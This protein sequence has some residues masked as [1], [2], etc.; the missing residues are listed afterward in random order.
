MTTTA[1]QSHPTVTG[2]GVALAGSMAAGLAAGSHPTTLLFPGIDASWPRAL[3]TALVG[4]P[5][6]AGWVDTV[7]TDLDDWAQTPQVRALGL[8][9]DGFSP[10]LPTSPEA[11]IGP[12]AATGPFSLVGNLLTNLV[13]LAALDDEGLRAASTAASTRSAGHSAGLLAAVVATAR[14][15]DGLV[16]VAVAADAA[17][18][19]AIMGAQAA[20]HPWAV[21]DSAVA[22][23][24]A[25]EESAGTPMVAISGPRTARLAA[26]LAGIGAGERIAIGVVTGPTRHILAGDPT[27]LAHLRTGL[28]GLSQGEATKRAAGQLGGTPFRF[29]WEPLASSVP[30]HHPD[31]DGAA[32]DALARIAELGL[33]LPSIGAARITDPAT[34]QD[35]AAEGTLEAVV[36][37]VLAR[38]HDWASAVTRSVSAG[39]VAIMVSPM[40]ALAG[41]TAADLRGRAAL[42]IDPST[43]AGRMALFTPGSAP[44]IP[45][46]YERFAP[47]AVRANDGTL[48]LANLHTRLSGRSPMILP[49][50]TPSTV[51]APIVVAAANGGHVAELAGGGQVTERIFTE[52]M[53]EV[54]EGLEP[55]QEVVLNALFLDPYLWNLQVGRERLVQRA[56]AAGAPINGVTISAG[57]PDKLEALA[58]LDELAAAGIWL[59]A[60]KPGTVAQVQEVLSI[61]AD[62]PHTLWIHLEG[63]TAGGHHSWE[64]LDELLLSTYHL[65]REHENVVLAVGGGIA[66]PERAGALLTGTWAHAH[67]AATMPVDAILLG[68]VTMATRE[69]AASPS[70]KAALVAAA[71]HDSWVARGSVAGGTTSGRSGLNADIHF[72]D[73]SAAGAARLLDS[74]AGDASAVQARRE[75]IIEALAATAKPYFGDVA[76]MTYAEMLARFVELA[77]LGRDGRY[78]DG[79]WL[80]ATHR[81]RFLALL[82]QAEARLNPADT[83]RIE[84]LFADPASVD[85]PSAALDQLVD[86][87]PAARTAL[88]HPADVAHYVSVARMPGKPVPFVPVID[89]DVRRWYQS[90]SLWQSHSDLFDADQVLIIPGPVAVSG[91]T[92]VDE[93]V[94]HLLDRFETSVAE[95]LAAPEPVGSDERNIADFRLGQNP[96]VPASGPEAL[97]AAA[98]AAP[99]WTWMGASRPNPLHRIGP[100]D[101]WSILGAIATWSSGESETAALTAEPDRAMALTLDWPDLGLPGDGELVLPVE[102]HTRAGVVTFE[103]TEQGLAVAGGGLLSMFAGGTGGP[104]SASEVAAAHAATVGAAGALPDR[105]MSAIWPAVFTRLAEAD[106]ASSMFDLVHLR[107]EIRTSPREAAGTAE[108]GRPELTRADGGLVITVDSRVGAVAVSDRFFVRRAVLDPAIPAA[109]APEARPGVVATPVRTLGTLTVTAPSRLEAFAVVSGDAN[110]IHR[111]NLLARFVG[112]PGRIV[113][114][115]WTS[116]AATRAVLESAAEGD[117]SRLRE[118]AIDFV[119]P[120]LPGQEVTFTVTRTGVRDGSRVVSVE[121]A[122]ADGVVA[123]G[124]A[125]VAGPRTMY[126]FPGQGIQSKGMGMEAYARSAAAR[127]A[128]D[129][130]DIATRERMGFSILAVVR[131]NPTTIE[132]VGTTYRHPAGVLHLTQFTQVAMA[133]LAAATVAEMREAGVF[134]PEAAVAGHSV[135]EYNALGASNGVLTLEGAIE[136]VFARGQGMHGLVPRD[137]AG[138]SDYRLAVIRPHLARLSHAQAEELVAG[139]A[140]DTGQL[141]EI[142]NHNLRGK[143][144]AVAGTLVSLAELERRIGPGQPSRPPMLLVPGIDVPFHSSALL[145]GVADFRKQ[146]VAKLPEHIDTAALVGRY[147][148]NLYPHLFRI[149]RE[150]VQGVHDVCASPILAEVLADWEAASADRD[151]LARTLVIELLAWQFASPVRWIETFELMCTPVELGGLGVE[152]IV[153]IGVGSAPTLANLA[154]GSLA[155]P[156]HRGSRPEVLNVEMDADAVLDTSEDPALA[157][158]EAEVAPEAAADAAPEAATDVTPATPAA[159]VGEAVPDL[160][161][162]HATAVAALLALRVGVRVDQL[163][164][165]SIESLVDG[166]SSRRNQVLMDI[167]REFGVSAMDGAH[168]VPLVELTS[169]LAEKTAG[170]RYPGPVLAA[171]VEGGLTAALGPRGS[172]QSALAKRVTAHWGLGEGWIARTSLALALGTREGSSRRGGDLAI[173]TESGAEGLI[174]EAVRAAAAEAGV[175]VAPLAAAATGGGTVDAAAV[176]ELREH[177]EGILVDQASEVLARLGRVPVSD[178]L[179][180]DYREALATLALLESEHGPASLVA[181]LFDPR[182]HVLLDS[183]STWARADVDHLVQGALAAEAGQQV[184]SLDELVE[185]VAAHRDADPRIRATLTYHRTRLAQAGHPATVAILDRALTGTPAGVPVPELEKLRSALPSGDPARVLAAAEALGEAP[186]DF[187]GEVALVTGA[188]PNSIALSSVAHLLRGGATV[189]LVTTT[190]TPERIAAYRDLERRYAGPGAQLHIVRA[191]LASFADIDALVEWMVTPTFEEVGPATREVKAALWPT[192][193]LP[194][195]AA[196]AMGELP[197]TGRDSQL[198]LRLLL[199][200]VQR[201]VGGLAERAGAARRDR[202]SVILPMSPNHGTFGGDGAYGDAKAALETMA[203]KWS[204]EGSRWGDQTRILSAEIGWVRGTGLM[205]ANDRVA[206]YIEDELGV[207]TYS[208]DQMGALI[209]A[210]AT[211]PFREQA[212]RAPLRLDLSGGLA[213]RADLGAAL[214]NAVAELSSATAS[215]TGDAVVDGT[216]AALPNLPALLAGARGP[217]EVASGTSRATVRA[218]DMIVMVGIAEYGPWGGSATR[219]QAEVGDLGSAGVVELA[220]R[221]GLI[222]WDRSAGGWVDVESGSPVAE[223]DLADRYRAPVQARSG[224][225]LFEDDEAVAAEGVWE[226]T[227]VFLDRALTKVVRAEAEARALAATAPGALVTQVEEG[228][229]LT[230]PAGASVRIPRRRPLLRSAGGQFPLGSDPTRHGLDSGIA[231]SMD[232]LTAWNVVITAEALADAGVTAEELVG[233]VHP[234]LVGNTQGSG[235][236]GMSSISKVFMG[237]LAGR[238]HANDVLQEALGNVVSAH[239]NQGLIGGYGPM[240]HP[241]AACATAAVSLEEAVDKIALGKAEIIIGGGWDDLSTEGITGFAN[242]AATADNAALIESGLYP[243]QHSRP[244]DRRRRGFVESQG[245]GSFIICRG[246]VALALGLPVRAVVGYAASFGDGIHTSIP[247]PGLGAL[248]SVRGGADSPLGRALAGLGLTADDVAVV[249]KHD[250]STEANDPNEA[251]IHETIQQA[252][253]RTPGAPLRVISQKSLTGH[254]KGG[255]AAWQM[256]GLC[257]VFQTATVPGNANLV[258]A[259]PRVTPGDAL[260]VDYRTLNRAEPVRAALVTSLGFGHVSA[261]VALAHPDVFVEAIPSGQRTAYVQRAHS[262][263][264]AG[265]RAR[266]DASHGGDALLA[267]RTDR[268]LGQGSSQELRARETG[269]LLD[270]AG[271]LPGLAGA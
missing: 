157:P 260:V 109:S 73:N 269:M 18:I 246:S 202:F 8:F 124:S 161:V 2:S 228:W 36:T 39:T 75:E 68:T 33:A 99:T 165:D 22:A 224:V 261:V 126:V 59:N 16:P 107:H 194:F 90:D 198:T 262:R 25:G 3:A 103:V 115:M 185:Q 176:N 80:D 248:G 168:E 131:D 201:L 221:C 78:E 223:A 128:W 87:Y 12:V 150:Y 218:E 169:T 207:V 120:L 226:F 104:M 77:A 91:I 271:T 134:D 229:L 215:G 31:L 28:E 195:A 63:G 7:V 192:L 209:A 106:L 231:G 95:A 125:V 225:R 123:L 13:A 158:V 222:E 255:A 211:A 56:R 21:S 247:A 183:A 60:F 159:L 205:A 105:V 34:G 164:H 212:D 5:D 250:T 53:T 6:L 187:G 204:S 118:W 29:A 92:T 46:T 102:V 227:E 259:D 85:D 24:L 62:T 166:A 76:E 243:H 50:M 177:V 81:S 86:A 54:A 170:Y 101:E 51:E 208:A 98:L 38:P 182:R 57:I 43:T 174:D 66:D 253:G 116:A 162:A 186:A 140:A 251:F 242:M 190:D 117:S 264:V 239:V 17:R 214:A 178:P 252:L 235:M 71:G 263:R 35:L 172:S 141:C 42:V 200:G 70:V 268:R 219:W 122:T 72:L 84:S 181:P 93:P 10:L 37:S 82:Q 232:A 26:I 151:A 270:P 65:I 133:T 245:G 189:V 154:K 30:F 188:S 206:R 11:P 119:A 147:I 58:L 203:N 61:A 130:A 236:G 89:A 41:Q 113:H 52:R 155:L 19:A 138:N 265:A 129:R 55:G 230:L 45:E 20:R 267:R 121:A 249:S 48:R 199:L 69:S 74:V 244:G 15:R 193:V 44:A 96:G 163:E 9:A 196:P 179:D 148:P 180:A 171:A 257:D 234:S 197:D 173:L 1:G 144:Y 233:A 238:Q 110:P 47:R 137:A 132:A 191:N 210:L 184:G 237:P 258:S 88:I 67:G 114:G 40:G 94:A 127:S 139:V 112:L 217:V 241:V 49:G 32:Q 4:R 254:S 240:V 111:S 79:A 135:G 167:G 100:A 108:A 14:G 149:D 64:D 142:V 216:V 153:E 156:T 220:W 152:R 213:G 97:L 136:L 175:P 145:G 23:A 160:P 27:A 266:L 256:A 83:G 143:Q 146:L